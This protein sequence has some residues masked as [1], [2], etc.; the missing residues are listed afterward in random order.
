MARM[1]V[2]RMFGRVAT[3]LLLYDWQKVSG[4][5]WHGCMCIQRVL[6]LIPVD[7]D[8]FPLSA[9]AECKSRR[10]IVD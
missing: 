10:W 3:V 4:M 7:G 9:F 2:K 1:R 6:P 5:G 8:R